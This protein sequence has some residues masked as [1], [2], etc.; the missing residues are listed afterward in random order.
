M[1]VVL[2]HETQVKTIKKILQRKALEVRNN[3]ENRAGYL[4]T[5]IAFMRAQVTD[6]TGLPGLLIFSWRSRPTTY[7][8]TAGGAG[9]H[10]SRKRTR[11]K[12]DEEEG[13]DNS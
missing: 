2:L 11:K 8:L 9:I 12:E 5:C 1:I 3:L 7:F 4:L 13:K 10:C 6:D